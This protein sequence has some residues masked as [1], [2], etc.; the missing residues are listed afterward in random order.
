MILKKNKIEKSKI[1]LFIYLLAL[2]VIFL[3]IYTL[4]I[5]NYQK[6]DIFDYTVF[7]CNENNL[8]EYINISNNFLILKLITNCCGTEFK[9]YKN[10]IDVF[11]EEI[12]TGPLCRCVCSRNILIYPF[13]KENRLIIIKRDCKYYLEKIEKNYYELK[14]LNKKC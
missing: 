13:K 1:D 7:D 5:I 11:V 3:I 8:E 4:L 14:E 2:I 12:V 6:Q 10:R 9:V